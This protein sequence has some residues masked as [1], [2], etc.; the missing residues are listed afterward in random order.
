MFNSYLSPYWYHPYHGLHVETL[1]T[2]DLKI[3]GRKSSQD[4]LQLVPHILQS[5]ITKLRNWNDRGVDGSSSECRYCA[6]PPTPKKKVSWYHLVR[7]LWYDEGLPRR[8]H[9][10]FSSAVNYIN[11]SDVFTSLRMRI[12]RFSNNNRFFRFLLNC[13]RCSFA[14][15][16]RRLIPF[17]QLS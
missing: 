13:F 8:L 4:N 3:G 11:L 9:I 7:K 16:W 15:K 6:E 12:N 14:F 17:S 1:L 5:D 2:A 10:M